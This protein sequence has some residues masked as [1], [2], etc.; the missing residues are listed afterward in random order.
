MSIQFIVG[1]SGV[2][3][4]VEHEGQRLGVMMAVAAGCGGGEGAV[5]VSV[6]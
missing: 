5:S 4:G 1:A 6:S 3:E 2:A